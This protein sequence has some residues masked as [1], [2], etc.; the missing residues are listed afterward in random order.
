V[1]RRIVDPATFHAKDDDAG[2]PSSVN[3]ARAL[4]SL[5]AD[6]LRRVET[7]VSLDD[8]LNPDSQV[9]SSVLS[10]P[11]SEGPDSFVDD[12]EEPPP[13]AVSPGS[14]KRTAPTSATMEVAAV[15]A[16]APAVPTVLVG[17]SIVLSALA[18]QMQKRAEDLVGTLV[19]SGFYSL[20]AK[21]SISKDT[22]T[23]IATMFGFR[24]ENAPPAPPSEPKPSS[25]KASS[26]KKAA[27]AKKPAP[28]KKASAKAKPASRR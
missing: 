17:S 13:T 5:R 19:A 9:D 23:T 24:V 15:A 28:K 21:S 14:G 10:G 27:A 8:E 20:H 18:A 6:E 3:V 2:P 25:A 12:E 26:K 7:L 4:A 11:I 16:P 22:A 1:R